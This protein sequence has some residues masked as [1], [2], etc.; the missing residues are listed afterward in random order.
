VGVVIRKAVDALTES[1]LTEEE[2]RIDREIEKL[3]FNK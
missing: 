2:M 3:H 1:D